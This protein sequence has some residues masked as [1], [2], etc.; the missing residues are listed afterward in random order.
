MLITVAHSSPW[1]EEAKKAGLR[2]TGSPEYPTSRTSTSSPKESKNM[3]V[4]KPRAKTSEQN[5]Y[6]G[7][8]VCNLRHHAP[9]ISLRLSLQL[10]PC[11][12]LLLS[13]ESCTSL[14]GISWDR[15]RHSTLLGTA[16]L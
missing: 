3:G 15:T 16:S 9:K 11:I 8:E 2:E 6:N 4:Q 7:T 13:H 1:R 10:L 5:Q 14:I 12:R